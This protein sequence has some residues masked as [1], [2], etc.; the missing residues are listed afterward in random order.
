MK[1][2]FKGQLPRYHLFQMT[3]LAASASE[4]RPTISSWANQNL[5][6]IKVGDT[7]ERRIERVR[8][9]FANEFLRAILQGVLG[10]QATSTGWRLW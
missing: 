10:L 3:L 7:V 1:D 5:Y 8:F 9:C 4:R 6:D 2:I